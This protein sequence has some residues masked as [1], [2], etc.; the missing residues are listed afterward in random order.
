MSNAYEQNLQKVTLVANADLED[1]QYYGV[2]LNS[3]EKVALASTGDKITGILQ[4]A[5]DA[6]NRSC[7]VAYGGISKAIGGEAIDAGAEVQTDADGKFITKTTGT[8]V[9]IA[10]TA[11]GAEDEHFSVLVLL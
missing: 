4:D 3:S 1:Y 10:M 7:L 2:K 9:G 6:A 8:G 11:C 5:P